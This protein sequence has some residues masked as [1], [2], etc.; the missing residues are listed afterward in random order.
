MFDDKIIIKINNQ[1]IKATSIRV[2]LFLDTCADQW[3]ASVPWDHGIDLNFDESTKPFGYQKAEVFVG[4]EKK[5]TGFLYDVL[6]VSDADG[7]R[8]ELTGFSKTIDIVD[9]NAI[10]P[11]QQSNVTLKQR[12]E[13]LLEPFSDISI[14]IQEGLDIGGIFK[15][16]VIKNDE[17]IFTHLQNLAKQRGVILSNDEEGDLILLNA[18]VNSAPVGTIEENVTPSS[19]SYMINFKGSERFSEYKCISKTPKKQSVTIEKDDNVKRYRLKTFIADTSTA[20]E[21]KKAAIWRKNKSIADAFTNDF[22]VIGFRNPSGEIWKLNTIITIKSATMSI[23]NGFNLLIRSLQ[24]DQD[25][26]GYLTTLGVIPPE[27]YTTEKIEE[28]WL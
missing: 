1:E 9:S 16:V 21:I 19:F 18:N 17:T 26:N 8:K 5:I 2:K 6:Q 13:K 15:R 7:R 20:G 23:S 22:P 28:P 27:A 25:P 14:K 24:F 10:P 12:A 3:T 4:G 11:Y